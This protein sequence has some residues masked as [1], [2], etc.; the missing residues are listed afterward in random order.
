MKKNSVGVHK[1]PRCPHINIFIFFCLFF[2]LSSSCFSV[3]HHRICSSSPSC[4]LNTNGHT[5]DEDFV[6]ICSSSSFF[7]V[8][9]NLVVDFTKWM[10]K[11]FPI[12]SKSINIIHLS[13]NWVA[14]SYFNMVLALMHQLCVFMWRIVFKKVSRFFQKISSFTGSKTWNI[15]LKLVDKTWNLL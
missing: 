1:L 7:S 10:R 13:I 3:L 4:K 5:I 6:L 14:N 9:H 11:T 15:L 8:L 12:C 2:S